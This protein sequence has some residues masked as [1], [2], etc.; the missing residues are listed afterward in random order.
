MSARAKIQSFDGIQEI[1]SVQF[2]G[3]FSFSCYLGAFH[4]AVY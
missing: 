1:L 4:Y 2:Y 3:P